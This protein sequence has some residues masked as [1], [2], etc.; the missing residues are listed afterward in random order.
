[1]WIIIG[2]VVLVVAGVVGGLLIG[3]RNKDKVEK[4]VAVA[5]KV[6]EGIKNVVDEIRK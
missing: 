3:R 6:G 4:G 1:M 2:L 5:E